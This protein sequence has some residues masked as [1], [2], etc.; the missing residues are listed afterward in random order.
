MKDLSLIIPTFNEREN[1][2]ITIPK[3]V[4]A[5]QK[6]KDLD[7]EIVVVDD[8]SPDGTAKT[9]KKL[10]EKNPVKVIVR[11]KNRGLSEAVMEGFKK[12]NSK[13]LGVMDADLSH[14][15]KKIP[16]LLKPLLEKKADIVIGSRH[17]KGAKI[18]DWPFIR[19]IIS[20]GAILLAKPL[21]RVKDPVS[22]FVFLNRK[23]IENAELNPT[24]FKITLEIL[25]K[26]NYSRVKEVPIIF[27]D[28]EL[29]KSKLNKSQIFL[30]LKHLLQL[31]SYKIRSLVK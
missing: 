3:I 12:T 24:G 26:G 1:I 5:L 14:S 18:K 8:N 4:K 17:A 21:T 20:I 16:Q 6:F 27:R 11:K 25:V 19:K 30:Y 31:Y 13:I 23:V 7:Y 22:G 29:G 28:R 9:A 10:A 15:P 2:Q